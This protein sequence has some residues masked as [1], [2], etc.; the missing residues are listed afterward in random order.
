V[1]IDMS[2]EIKD[3]ID[4]VGFCAD[5]FIKYELPEYWYDWECPRNMWKHISKGLTI[6]IET[7]KIF[8]GT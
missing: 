3:G 7:Q 1:E 8:G 2:L 5:Y 4:L 6:K